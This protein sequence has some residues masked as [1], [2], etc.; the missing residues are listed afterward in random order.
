MEVHHRNV[1]PIKPVQLMIRE[2]LVANW[3][4]MGFQTHAIKF[5]HKND[6]YGA[7]SGIG[8]CLGHFSEE[9]F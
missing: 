4:E 8:N 7:C 3:L 6:Y 2:I 9:E 1:F 5:S